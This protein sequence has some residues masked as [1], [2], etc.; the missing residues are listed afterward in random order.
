MAF[1][2]I[3]A[4]FVSVQ[5]QTADSSTESNAYQEWDN[6]KQAKCTAYIYAKVTAMNSS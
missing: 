6:S 4:L 5:K 2:T 1:T 3:S